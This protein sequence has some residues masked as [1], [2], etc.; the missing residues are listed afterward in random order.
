M[1]DVTIRPRAKLDLQNIWR[2]TLQHWGLNQA[3]QYIADLEQAIIAISENPQVG[4]AIDFVRP[5]YRK[6]IARHHL[7]IYRLNDISVEV[8][9]VLSQK[10]DISKQ[11]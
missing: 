10:M 6:T 7:I 1:L 2:F 5:G 8:A 11:V 4:L 3:N 9:R